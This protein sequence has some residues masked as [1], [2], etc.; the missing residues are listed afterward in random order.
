MNVNRREFLKI[1]ATALI[2]QGFGEFAFGEAA[3][4]DSGSEEI[5]LLPGA[6][7]GELVV[8]YRRENKFSVIETD[9]KTAHEVARI[10]WS[11]Y[12][13]VVVTEKF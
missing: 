13:W 12:H 6:F 5:A 9:L 4:N 3:V 1:S 10:P 11:Q 8:Y 2:F 7:S